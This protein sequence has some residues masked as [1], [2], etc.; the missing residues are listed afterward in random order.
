MNVGQ[1]VKL[2]RDIP[3]KKLRVGDVVRIEHVFTEPN[4]CMFVNVTNPRYG[5]NSDCQ[6]QTVH[7]DDVQEV[8]Q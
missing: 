3:A 5:R 1:E 7:I 2:V 6:Y 8:T 4:V